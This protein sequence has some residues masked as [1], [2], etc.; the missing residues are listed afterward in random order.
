MAPRI[1]ALIGGGQAAGKKSVCNAI[2]SRLQSWKVTDVKVLSLDNFK[3]A[4]I[5]NNVNPEGPDT[6]DFVAVASA[7]KS[8]TTDVLLVEGHYTLY[9][10]TLRR[11]G[12]IRI[13]IDL[14]ADTRLSRRIIRDTTQRGLSLQAVLD[15]YLD[16]GKIAMERYIQGTKPTADI[17]LMRGTEPSGIELIAGA[18]YDRLAADRAAASGDNTFNVLSDSTPAW[19]APNGLSL[20]HNLLDSEF[21]V[22]TENYYELA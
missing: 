5:P 21:E 9:E 8:E 2:V 17:V 7:I 22:Q 13:Y 12:T 16:Y 19:Q 11:L 6:Y 20:R 4:K 1:V 15:N 3:K 18:I 14:D 10:E